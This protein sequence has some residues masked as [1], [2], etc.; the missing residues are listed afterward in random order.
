M[1]I[2]YE[3]LSSLNNSNTDTIMF[4]DYYGGE[5]YNNIEV[6]GP[7]KAYSKDRT[8]IKNNNNF[9]VIVNFNKSSAGYAGGISSSEVPETLTAGSSYTITRQ[10]STAG[11]GSYY[12][13]IKDNKIT[14]VRRIS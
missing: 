8:S 6:T 1:A 10:Y 2:R 7:G 13:Y 3:D 9:T 4:L 14:S 5:M 11:G 12:D